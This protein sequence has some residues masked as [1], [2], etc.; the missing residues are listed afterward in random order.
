MDRIPNNYEFS[1]QDVIDLLQPAEHTLQG[2]FD[3]AENSYFNSSFVGNKDSLKSFRD[4][5]PFDF[6]INTKFFFLFDNSG[7][8]NSYIPALNWMYDNVLKNTL[9]PFYETEAQYNANAKKILFTHNSESLANFERTFAALHL[10]QPEQEILDPYDVDNIDK[11]VV[12]VYQDEAESVY[13][14]QTSFHDPHSDAFIN[15]ITNYKSFLATRSQGDYLGVALAVLSGNS[16][17]PQFSQF[18]NLTIRRGTTPFNN[19][20]HNVANSSLVKSGH[21]INPDDWGHPNT[22]IEQCGMLMYI[23]A[24]KNMIAGG[25]DNIQA[26]NVIINIE[27]TTEGL[28]GI[29]PVQWSKWGILRYE[30]KSFLF[31]INTFGVIDTYDPLVMNFSGLGIGVGEYEIAIYVNKSGGV[32]PTLFLETIPVILTTESQTINLIVEE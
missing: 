8:M 25:V 22:H 20:D 30:G 27:T 29:F 13:H 31:P 24:I 9:L 21:N 28:P 17:A 3:V 5:G 15:D 23:Q 18:I 26:G 7:S 32:M 12:V 14:G 2:C 16:A 6:D 1:L 19:P 10:Q 4:Y 11:F